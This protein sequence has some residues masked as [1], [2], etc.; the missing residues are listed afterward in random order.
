[1]RA[2]SLHETLASL[3]VP[4][5]ESRLLANQ[6]EAIVR[7]HPNRPDP[8]DQVQL[9]TQFLAL[10]RATPALRSSFAA[11]AFLY[12]R[13]YEGR[14]AAVGPGPAR[15]PPS[16]A[17]AASNL[18]QV[19]AA[20]GLT[21]YEDFWRWT[22]EHREAYWAAAI[23]RLGIVFRKRPEAIRDAR[24]PVTRPTWLPGAEL[25][26]AESCFRAEPSKTAIVWASEADPTI[27][28]ITYGEL[29]R[30]AAR[31][32]NGL[33]ALGVAQGERIALDLPMTPESVAIY[34]GAILAGRCVVGIADASAPP[35]V[36]KRLRIG[37]AKAVFTI[38]AYVRDGKEHG[39]YE[40][41]AELS[42]PRAV[43]LPTEGRESAHLRRP[44]DILW[45]DF[46]SDRDTFDAVPARPG[47][48]TNILFSSGTTKDPKAIVWTQT[49]PIKAAADAH[50]H[51]DVR[52]DD[53]LAWPTSFGWMMGPWLTYGSLVN[54]ATIALYV[55]AAQRRAY[56]AFVAEAGVTLLGVVPK[57]VRGWKADGAMEGLDWSRIRR[58]SS[59]GET[60]SPEEMLY[61]MSLAGYK[62]VIEY[63]GG[64]EIGGGYI[65]GTLVQ[66][67]APSCFS[68]P[69][70][71]IDFVI[72][73]DGHLADRGEVFLIPP[74]F[75]LSSELLNYDHFQEYFANVPPGPEGETLR[76]HGDQLE[77][78]GGGYLRH[79]GRIDDMVNIYGVKSSAEEIRS[80]LAHELVYDAKPVAVDV[81]DTG[82]HS[83]VIYAVPKDP[84]RV[85]DPELAGRL[86][87]DFERQIKARLNPLLAHVHDVVLVHELPQ[88]GPGKTKT[89]TA[90]RRDYEARRDR[91]GV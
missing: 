14:P 64:T 38:D 48:P 33:D 47:E 84:A 41:V 61:L 24:S 66:P 35:D 9:W 39:I 73:D 1:M 23:D 60:S 32:G 21:R 51:H 59:T 5:D 75:G 56:G 52:P 54:R 8:D 7:R 20:R 12:R 67:C 53:V 15:V 89:M 83:L 17:L 26:I 19:M 22:A 29:R 76:R 82:R 78:L 69:A 6:I 46:L 40:K 91:G 74:S 70:L 11:Q 3:S 13:A 37:G 16:D 25:N 43:V 2:P 36:E 63:C 50:F 28:R 55:G 27:R 77:R 44:S 80:V 31:V 87:E 79:H 34:L 90:L 30:L 71:G 65:T 57:L 10:I 4:E 85:E 49:T 18:G 45:S 62:P 58:F 72:L 68:T 42:A 88:A 81:G 86:R